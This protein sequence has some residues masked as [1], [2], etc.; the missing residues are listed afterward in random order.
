VYNMLV[1][2]YKLKIRLQAYC[3]NWKQYGKSAGGNNDDTGYNVSED[4]LSPEE[5]DG[6]REV[7]K[8]LAPFKKL[9]KQIERREIG[10]QDY[11][12]YCDKILN[13]LHK[14]CRQF[15]RQADSESSNS[16]SEA[17]RWL[18]ICTESALD[19]AKE[20]F[21][22]VDDSPAY[23][24][25]RVIDPR[26]KFEWFEQRW[27]TDPEK[28]KL[29]Q[30]MKAVVKDHWQTYRS[31]YHSQETQDVNLISRQIQRINLGKNSDKNDSD[32]DNDDSLNMGAYMS[33]S[34]GP[35]SN[36]EVD[37]FGEYVTS[38]PQE[39]FQ[40]SQWQLIEQKHPELVQFALDHA[41]IPI[42][43]SECERSFSSAKFALNPLRSRMKSDLFEALETLRAWYLEDEGQRKRLKQRK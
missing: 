23:Y 11:I 8:V 42:S 29:L 5:W 21:K 17:Y 3:E 16:Q 41:A 31:R 2:A 36:R 14:A 25:A 6:V 19:K 22:R 1:R 39:D 30:G 15:K 24:T 10:L 28:R 26:F 7:I 4:K 27:G 12:P 18:Q 38:T 37:V 33:T 13:H 9:T 20:L 40:L 34:Y 32:D 35:T 43:S